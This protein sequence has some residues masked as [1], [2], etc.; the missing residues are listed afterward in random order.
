MPVTIEEIRGDVVPERRDEQPRSNAQPGPSP[1]Q[2]EDQ[3]RA[4]MA[5]ERR[6]AERLCDR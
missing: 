6:R 3:V 4:L 2:I 5:R 1:A